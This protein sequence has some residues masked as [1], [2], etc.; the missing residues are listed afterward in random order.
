[1]CFVLVLHRNVVLTETYYTQVFCRYLLFNILPTVADI[2]IA[3]V[4]FVSM[5]NAW[6]GL[7]V[8]VTMLLYLGITVFSFKTYAHLFLIEKVFLN[9]IFNITAATFTITEWRTKYRREMNTLDNEMEAKGVD[10][11]L[12]F[13]TVGLLLDCIFKVKFYASL[14]R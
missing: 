12:N 4:F 7:I 9:H 10:S 3:I 6:F 8:F 2:V 1:M 14:C 5:F 11:L 13:E